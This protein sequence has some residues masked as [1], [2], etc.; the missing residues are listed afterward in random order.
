MHHNIFKLSL[1][2]FALLLTSATVAEAVS[3]EL[4]GDPIQEVV[5][6]TSDIPV[7]SGGSSANFPSSAPL[8]SYAQFRVKKEGET[9]EF[10]QLRIT[11]SGDNGV[12]DNKV[13]IAQTS[14]SQGLTD[15][16]TASILLTLDQNAGSG[17]FTFNWYEPSVGGTSTTPKDLAVLYTTY[18]LDY[19]QQIS[20]D[21][22]EAQSITLDGST[23]LTSTI[24]STTEVYDGANSN[25]SFNEPKNAVQILSENSASHTFSVGKHT[26]SG[27]ALYMFEFRDPSNNISFTNPNTQQVPFEFSPSLGLVVCGGLFGANKLRK[28]IAS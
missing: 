4:F 1:L 24:D 23:K 11:Y 2:S 3:L 9:N 5:G 8:G 10:A 28:R 26:D 15:T 13:M 17:E 22:S 7:N 21:S 18:D 25:S 27:N 20:F 16:G 19:N 14:D 12:T 6:T